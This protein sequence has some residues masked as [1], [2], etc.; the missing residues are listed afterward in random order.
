MLALAGW[1]RVS[2]IL[3]CFCSRALQGNGSTAN[4]YRNTNELRH[5]NN[6]GT[7][8]GL[9]L[10]SEYERIARARQAIVNL[11]DYCQR[12]SAGVIEYCDT[13]LGAKSDFGS[14]FGR[15]ADYLRMA[16]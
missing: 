5:L 11:H 4:G 6:K 10:S 15:V 7:K 12:E 3:L 2:Q 16:A 14:V 1:L 8:E 13:A 9:H